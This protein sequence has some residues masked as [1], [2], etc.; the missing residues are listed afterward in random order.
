MFIPSSAEMRQVGEKLIRELNCREKTSERKASNTDT[1]ARQIIR[2]IALIISSIHLMMACANSVD[3]L[4]LPLFIFGTQWT[5]RL[6][7]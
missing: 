1:T 6:M 5:D 7:D 3:L 4:A 2:D